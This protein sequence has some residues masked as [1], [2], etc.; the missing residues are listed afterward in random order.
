MRPRSPQ[1]RGGAHVPAGP[2]R[3]SP[4]ERPWRTMF[5]ATVSA[6]C[7]PCAETRAPCSGAQRASQKRGP[8]RRKAAD[9]RQPRTP[10]SGAHCA[11]QNADP[12]VTKTRTRSPQNRG[13]AHVPAGPVRPSPIERPWR[14]MFAAT[15]SVFCTPCA[16]TRAPCSGAQR[17][18]QN[19]DLCAVIPRTRSPRNRS[20]AHVPAGPVRPSPDE[21]PWR[22]MFAATVSVFC[23]PCAETRAPCSGAQRAP[24]NADLCAVIPRTR[25]PRNRSGAHVPAGPVRPSPD[26]RPW[27][28]MFAATVSVFCTPCA[29]TRAPCS[30]AQRAP[31][32]CGPVRRE[33]AAGAH[34]PA[35]PVRP[36]PIERPWRTMF[37]ATVSAFCTPCAKPRTPCSGAHCA[38]QNADP[39]ATKPRRGTRSGRACT[40]LA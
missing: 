6:F 16:E 26:E 10:C 3:P 5:A 19:A 1:N 36:S 4:I 9:L 11:P 2:V 7:T 37:A 31:Q 40:P 35:G 21:R 20:G 8:V 32:K 27:R 28:T 15:V 14:T 18:P 29:E 34:V 17:A 24:Q 30:G 22:T 12:F 33:T 38:P 23:T 25:S 13:G 39:F